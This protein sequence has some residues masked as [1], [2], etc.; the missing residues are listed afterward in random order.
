MP[1]GA[2][3]EITESGLDIDPFVAL[4]EKPEIELAVVFEV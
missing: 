3:G 4:I 2:A 1:L